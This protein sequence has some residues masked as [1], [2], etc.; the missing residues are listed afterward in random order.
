[1]HTLH[2]RCFHIIPANATAPPTTSTISLPHPLVITASPVCKPGLALADVDPTPAVPVGVSA[3]PSPAPTTVTA[4]MMD[5]LPSGR[6]EVCTT[7][8][9]RGPAWCVLVDVTPFPEG[10][11]VVA[12]PPTVDMMVKPTPLVVVMSSPAVREMELAVVLG[13][14]DVI[15]GAE[16]LT[17]PAE[18]ADVAEGTGVPFEVVLAEVGG[19][20]DGSV[21]DASSMVDPSDIGGTG[22]GKCAVVWGLGVAGVFVVAVPLS[23]TWRLLRSTTSLF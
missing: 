20:L 3:A 6:E 7:K 19:V 18:V 1:M 2:A 22:V 13:V 17:A 9:V 4:V 15:D 21:V 23:A 10:E 11:M 14:E 5:L 12:P 16:E 8:L